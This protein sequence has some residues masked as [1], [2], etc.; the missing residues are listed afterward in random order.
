VTDEEA[1]MRELPKAA[2]EA[3]ERDQD[4]TALLAAVAAQPERRPPDA[5]YPEF[6]RL[7]DVELCGQAYRV[8]RLVDLDD[9]Q[10]RLFIE[11]TDVPAYDGE[12]VPYQ[13]QGK[14]LRRW[15]RDES[16][17]PAKDDIDWDSYR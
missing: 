15:V 4:E 2:W 7:R 17:Y 5:D 3:Y 13:L 6:H 11:P 12:G 9:G 10:E 14:A 1:A 16:A 8:C